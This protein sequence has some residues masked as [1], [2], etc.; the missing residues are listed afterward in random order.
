PREI[1]AIFQDRQEHEE[2]R[3]LRDEDDDRA[4]AGENAIF[5]QIFNGTFWKPRRD[6]RAG[7]GDDM[8]DAFHHRLGEPEDGDEEGAHDQGEDE[9]A[10]DFVD[11]DGIDTVREIEGFGG[12]VGENVGF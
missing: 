12:F 5:Y 4:D 11:E 2:Q 6:K 9:Q 3:D 1:T 8:L 7:R 10:P